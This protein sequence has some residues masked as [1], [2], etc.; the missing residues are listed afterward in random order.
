M[1]QKQYLKQPRQG[2]DAW[3]PK[4]EDE[5]QGLTTKGELLGGQKCF[6]FDCSDAHTTLSICQN[7]WNGTPKKCRF[8]VCKL[9]LDKSDSKY[10]WS[11]NGG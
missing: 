1:S 4:V 6:G 11:G 3:L 7:S 5:E 9:Y 10:Q 2:T 8:F